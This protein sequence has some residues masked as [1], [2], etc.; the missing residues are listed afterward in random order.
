MLRTMQESASAAGF[1]SHGGD[2]W[3]FA[4]ALW[5]EKNLRQP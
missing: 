1:E 2:A 3:A 4:R 5:A